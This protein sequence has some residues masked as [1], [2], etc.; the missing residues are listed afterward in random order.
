MNAETCLEKLDLITTLSMATVDEDGMPQNRIIS[1]IYIEDN[2]FYFFT[3]RGK[4]FARQ[5]KQTNKVAILGLSKFKEQIRLTGIVK[6][7]EEN[8]Q[9]KYI[10]LIFEKYP[11]LYNVYPDKTNEIGMV[12]KIKD[13]EIEYF[14]LAVKPIFRQTYTLGDYTAKEKGFKIAEDECIGCETCM[15]NCPQKSIVKNDK[16]EISQNHCLHCGNCYKHCPQG[17]VKHL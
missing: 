1:A 11:Y 4:E 17:A 16:F 12:F 8:N 10:D 2:Q 14:N 9:R 15:R 6:A 3:A 7:V 5:L 13:C